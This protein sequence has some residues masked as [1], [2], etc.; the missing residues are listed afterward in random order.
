MIDNRSKKSTR[1]D[2]AAWISQLSEDIVRT[3]FRGSGYF[4][5]AISDDDDE[6]V[7][8]FDPLGVLDPME[9][10]LEESTTK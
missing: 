3:S 1:Q 6:L 9:N 2:I 7:M 5:K 8:E 10:A 4:G